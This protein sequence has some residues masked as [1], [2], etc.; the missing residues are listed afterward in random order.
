MVRMLAGC[1]HRQLVGIWVPHDG[2]DGRAIQAGGCHVSEC[3][4]LGIG[5]LPVVG[6]GC[7]VGPEVNLA[8]GDHHGGGRPQLQ[9][10]RRCRKRVQFQASTRTLTSI[11]K[12]KSCHCHTTRGRSAKG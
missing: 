4:I 8:T 3:L 1:L 10:Q 2:M 7:A 12:H 5:R 11:Q 6:G 9:G